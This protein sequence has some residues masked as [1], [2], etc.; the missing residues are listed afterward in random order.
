[1][2][3]QSSGFIFRPEV[4]TRPRAEQIALD[5]ALFR[6]QMRYL[7]ERSAFHRAK[8]RHAGFAGAD[9]AGDLDR[10][11]QL[12]FTEKDEIRASQ[13]AEPP[14]GSHRAAPPESIVRIYSTSGTTGEPCYMPLTAKDLAVWIEI[15]SR[16]YTATGLRRGQR[17][18]STYNAG[19]FVAGAAL[20]AFGNIG[21]C[22]I[23]VGT[24]N[25]ERLARALQVIR[26]EAL[27]CT[28]SYAQYLAEW[29]RARAI[30][31]AS[32]GLRRISVAGEPGGGEP[33]FRA[34]IEAAFGAKVCEA[35]GIGDISISL[36]GECE[37]QQGMH[38]CGGDFVHVEL[39]DPASGEALPLE[40]GAEG[41]LVYT[42]LQREA[43]PA[44]RFRSRD[45]VVI[46]IAPCACGRRT[47]RTR[48][49]GRTDDMLIVR[50]VN[51]FPTA[52]RDVVAGF[53][54]EVSGALL[55]KPAAPGTRQEPPLP[56][57]VELGEDVAARDDLAERIEAAIRAKLVATTRVTLVPYASLPRSEYKTK[58]VKHG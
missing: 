15:S 44:L 34:A 10:I 5:R 42:A 48:C 23:P 40:D 37:H 43:A 18:A 45:H 12:P 47:I 51:L 41:E 24:G 25:T 36:W 6:R 26:P 30:D 50:G 57:D 14:L 2:N 38:F 52:I 17:M 32:L 22:H 53:R 27:V 28:P 13:A 8:L 9:A 7:F 35:M 49:I 46:W 20:D 21:A 56:L 58:L 33:A 55:V 54:P 16:A 3:D 11:A 19:P 4:E 39:I 1:M 31:P 29:L